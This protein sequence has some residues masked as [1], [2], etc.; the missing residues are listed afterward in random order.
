MSVKLQLA[1]GDDFG[2]QL[3]NVG[4]ELHRV[5]FLDVE[6]E[7]ARFHFV[8]CNEFVNQPHH[9]FGVLDGGIEFLRCV[10]LQSVV[11]RNIFERHHD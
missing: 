3:Y 9:L 8:E 2:E 5:A 6:P 10:G 7:C 1:F 11:L 4:N